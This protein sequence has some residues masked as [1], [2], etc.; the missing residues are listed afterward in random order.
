MPDCELLA[1]CP[2]YNDYFQDI[3]EPNTNFKEEYCHGNFVWC[4]RYIIFKRI[5]EE[6]KLM[7]KSIVAVSGVVNSHEIQRLT[8]AVKHDI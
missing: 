2:F 1:N 7:G 8:H 6:K 5:N 4:G 3:S